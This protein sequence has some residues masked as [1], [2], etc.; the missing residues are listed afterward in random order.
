MNK[1]RMRLSRR[2][3]FGFGRFDWLELEC[4]VDARTR[5]SSTNDPFELEP[6]HADEAEVVA[7]RLEVA[8]ALRL[9]E[10]YASYVMKNRRKALVTPKVE[11]VDQRLVL[12]CET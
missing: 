10:R 5:V 12:R 7:P 9:A 6:V 11:V 8:E 3:N 2:D 4:L 1:E